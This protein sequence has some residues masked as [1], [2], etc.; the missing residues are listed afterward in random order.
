MLLMYSLRLLSSDVKIGRVY[1]QLLMILDM[2]L[3]II[4][5]LHVYIPNIHIYT[6]FLVCIQIVEFVISK[7]KILF[8][9]KQ[10]ANFQM[11]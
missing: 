8:E 5:Q 6:W 2:L 11:W 4:V 1:K 3:Y 9:L 7:T 10:Q